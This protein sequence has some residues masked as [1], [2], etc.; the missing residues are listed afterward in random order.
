MHIFTS[1]LNHGTISKN[2]CLHLK[3]K[4]HFHSQNRCREVILCHL[5]DYPHITTLHLA[6]QNEWRLPFSWPL[7]EVTAEWRLRPLLPNHVVDQIIKARTEAPLHVRSNK[8]WPATVCHKTGAVF[9]TLP[10]P[11]PEDLWH[12]Q[13]AT[14][15]LVIYKP[16][17]FLLN[18]H[19]ICTFPFF[20]SH[21]KRLNLR[22]T[23]CPTPLYPEDPETPRTTKVRKRPLDLK[24]S[25]SWF[26]HL[27]RCILNKQGAMDTIFFNHNAV[28]WIM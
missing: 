8:T 5:S 10:V 20:P 2:A 7:Q 15:M 19:S 22:V 27:W 14:M 11:V 13:S 1:H 25:V 24:F 9:P 26:P 16:F 4:W 21:S 23:L 6:P 17:V 18:P 3:C 28:T 12:S